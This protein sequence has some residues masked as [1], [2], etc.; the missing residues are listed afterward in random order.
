MG[1]IVDGLHRLAGLVAGV[2]FVFF[3]AAG[4]VLVQ[5]GHVVHLLLA[6]AG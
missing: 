3:D 1:E 2:A 5:E 6:Q 4:D